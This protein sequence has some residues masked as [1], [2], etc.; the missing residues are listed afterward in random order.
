VQRIY[1]NAPGIEIADIPAEVIKGVVRYC[2]RNELNVLETLMCVQYDHGNKNWCFSNH[3][4][5]HGIEE[6]G[7]IHT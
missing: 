6:D 3:G 7:H 4:M 1:Q 2:K 5:Y